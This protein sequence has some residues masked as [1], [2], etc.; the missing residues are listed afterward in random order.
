M[1]DLKNIFVKMLIPSVELYAFGIV[2]EIYKFFL[3]QLTLKRNSTSLPHLRCEYIE[4][5]RF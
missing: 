2:P 5:A 4:D 3:E 1:A